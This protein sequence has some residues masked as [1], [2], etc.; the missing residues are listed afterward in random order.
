MYAQLRTCWEES[1]FGESLS[2]LYWIPPRNLDVQLCT[3]RW[4]PDHTVSYGDVFHRTLRAIV[5][6]PCFHVNTDRS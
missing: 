2:E 3:L 1:E 4:R 5:S 6:A